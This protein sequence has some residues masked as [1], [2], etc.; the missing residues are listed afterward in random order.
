MCESVWE[1]FW[2]KIGLNL[3]NKARFKHHFMCF[4]V[5]LVKV[6]QDFQQLSIT[7]E[8]LFCRLKPRSDCLCFHRNSTRVTWSPRCWLPTAWTSSFSLRCVCRLFQ[9][10]CANRAHRHANVR[11]FHQNNN[12][13]VFL[14]SSHCAIE[15]FIVLNRRYFLPYFNSFVTL[16]QF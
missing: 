12:I 1:F 9:R 16:N 13:Q 14:V 10:S 5:E 8:M 11:R 3:E 15:K 4:Y 6:F 2:C 7:M